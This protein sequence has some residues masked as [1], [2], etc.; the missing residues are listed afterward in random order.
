[1]NRLRG[2]A[3]LLLAVLPPRDSPWQWPSFRGEGQAVSV[4]KVYR[5]DI[6][7]VHSANFLLDRRLYSFE[8]EISLLERDPTY[9]IHPQTFG[10]FLRKTRMDRELM[11]KDVAA[12]LGTT[13][14]TIINWELR[15]VKPTL[16][17]HRK[18]LVEFL[19][20]RIYDGRIPTV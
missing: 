5:R 17:H 6:P 15:D 20:P 13:E 10:Q 16:K 9:P 2:I 7:S 12:I 14:D 1:V 8:F 4:A 19:G 11:I 18:G 3:H